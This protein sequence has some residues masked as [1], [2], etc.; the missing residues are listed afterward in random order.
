MYKQE[1]LIEAGALMEMLGYTDERSLKKW[2]KAREIPLLRIG[3]KRYI[4][5]HYLT[6]YIDN[7]LVIFGNGKMLKPE[8]GSDQLKEEIENPNVT[9]EISKSTKRSKAATSFMDKIKGYEK[10]S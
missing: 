4:L 7:Q 6:Q 2:C 3:L 10:N 1:D 5:S 8:T 9:N